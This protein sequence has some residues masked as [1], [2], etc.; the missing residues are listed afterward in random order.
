MEFHKYFYMWS[1]TICFYKYSSLF[2]EVPIYNYKRILCYT[3]KETIFHINSLGFINILL[4]VSF[5]SFILCTLSVPTP[6][7]LF[8]SIF[9]GI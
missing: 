3:Q 1:S 2:K 7:I 8:V 5:F 6:K 4:C 9:F